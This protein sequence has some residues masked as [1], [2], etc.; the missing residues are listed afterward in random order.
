[1]I[2]EL[3]D[4][5]RIVGSV[6]DIIKQSSI[7]KTQGTFWSWLS[8]RTNLVPKAD[9][10]VPVFYEEYPLITGQAERIRIHAE[11]G[12][13]PDE[14][15]I[16]RSPNM[17]QKEFDYVKSNFKQTSL[18]VF[19]DYINTIGRCFSD[20]NWN[21]DY[22][23]DG[24]KEVD[25]DS[26][27]HYLENG[28]KHYG[29]LENFIKFT[30]PTLMTID[31]MGIIAINIPGFP[32]KANEEGELIYDESELLQPQPYYHP[33]KNIL[34]YKDDEYYLALLNEKCWIDYHGSRKKEGLVFYFYD[35]NNIWRIEQ[36]GKYVDF[37][38]EYTL[39]YEHGWGQV[40]CQRLG[41]IPKI[42][43]DK[44]IQQ[45]DFLYVCDL[46]DIVLL[47]SSNLFIVKSKC[48]YPYRIS[49]GDV[50]EFKD[51]Q[52]N[53]CTDGMIWSNASNAGHGAHIPCPACYGIGLR[54]RITPLGELL[55]KPSTRENVGGDALTADEAM[56]FVGPSKDMFEVL[57]G[58]IDKNLKQSRDIMHV[59]QSNSEVK[60]NPNDTALGMAIDEKS[61]AAFIK[62][63][64][65]RM[66]GKYDWLIYG[67]SY[68]RYRKESEHVLTYPTNFDFNTDA[69][70]LFQIGEAKKNGLPPVV[71]ETKIDKYLQSSYYSEKSTADIYNL[72]SKADRIIALN[73]E[74][75]SFGLTR[76]LIQKWEAILHDS[77]LTL[78]QELLRENEKFFEQDLTAQIEALKVKAQAIA[79]AIVP[80]A[81]AA[82]AT[83]AAVTDILGG[84]VEPGSELGKLPLAAQQ[85]GLALM[86]ANEA[87]NS[88]L[89]SQIEKKMKEV[90]ASINP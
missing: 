12:I 1:M 69:D 37:K 71:I 21:I 55:L 8:N 28:I 17:V 77:G 22:K 46:L 86:R 41:G 90:I 36:T 38:F 83:Q 2:Y 67:I 66:F 35:K 9:S 68:M 65:D 81:P 89:A 31:A 10:K 43:G 5:E 45:S 64:S 54:S 15:F 19:I 63:K 78:I 87:G 52:G 24:K 60:G 51:S 76:G 6:V 72:I 49:V 33:S 42:I 88:A 75:I 32:T 73:N 56:K 11:P 79:T 50:C 82:G 4:I 84:G 16:V 58:E 47:D 62:P 61:M 40:P 27:R 70:Y 80:A 23:E 26:L 34:A 30:L 53:Q 85:L 57:I 25:E 7:I 20:D 39:W 74:D 13:F 29:S 44:L 48:A 18:P 59:Y 14:L 3:P